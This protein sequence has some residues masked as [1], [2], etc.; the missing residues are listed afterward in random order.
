MHRCQLLTSVAASGSL[1]LV[2]SNL[3]DQEACR[4]LATLKEARNS[5][6]EKH[7]SAIGV[8]AGTGVKKPV[9]SATIDL[10]PASKTYSQVAHRLPIPPRYSIVQPGEPRTGRRSGRCDLLNRSANEKAM[11]C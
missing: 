4:T 8:D 11:V 6:P 1:A 2:G 9:D 7:V 10:N 3:R 5:P